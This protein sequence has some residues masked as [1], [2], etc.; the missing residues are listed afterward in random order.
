MQ[1]SL[2]PLNISCSHTQLVP[3]PTVT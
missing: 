2:T 1:H 3:S